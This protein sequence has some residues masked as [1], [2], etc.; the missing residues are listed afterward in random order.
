M[1]VITNQY[2]ILL[3]L[4]PQKSESVAAAVTH[5]NY[6]PAPPAQKVPGSLFIY[7]FIYSCF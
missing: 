2:D 6:A 1:V 3:F 5:Q 4:P 7:F